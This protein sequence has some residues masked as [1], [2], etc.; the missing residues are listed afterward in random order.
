MQ[1]LENQNREHVLGKSKTLDNIN[2]ICLITCILVTL[3]TNHHSKNR[4]WLPNLLWYDR[5]VAVKWLWWDRE[6]C[7]DL[8]IYLFQVYW[9]GAM[10]TNKA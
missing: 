6:S 9:A 8:F 7:L 1:H 4:W 2:N 10:H 3:Q 5:V